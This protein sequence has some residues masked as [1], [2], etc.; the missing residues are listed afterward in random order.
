MLTRVSPF[1]YYPALGLVI[2]LQEIEF[3]VKII[4]LERRSKWSE[5][6]AKNTAATTCTDETTNTG[7]PTFLRRNHQVV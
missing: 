6:I 1:W 5:E 2:L 3:A 7:L 4:L